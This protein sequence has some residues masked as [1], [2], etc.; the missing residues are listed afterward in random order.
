MKLVFF[1]TPRF[2]ATILNYLIAQQAEIIAVVSRPDK[3]Q[4]RS[5]KPLPTP[6]K[7]LAAHFNLPVYQPQ[8]VS[9]PVF[10]SFLRSLNAD[11]FIVAAFAEIFKENVLE[12]PKLG[13]INVHASI[14]PKYRGA[15]PIERAV[16]AGE[17]ESGV[18]IMRMAKDLDVGDILTIA[19]APIH[20]NMTAGE[21]S[22][23]LSQIGAQALWE[24]IQKLKMGTLQS[25]KQ[26]STLA[27]YAKKL[28]PEEGE[29]NWQRPFEEVH[30]H[31]RGVTPKPGA[32][33][34]VSIR[35]QK[36]RLLIKKALKEPNRSGQPGEILSQHPLEL[37]VACLT[38]ACRL[39]EV[40]LE[41]KKAMP[42]ET[43]LR[44]ISLTQIKF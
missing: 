31:I 32:W 16:M 19:K 25:F 7:E 10:A 5:A 14:L 37:V 1:G 26:D 12:I 15:A 2:A 23:V 6:V 17:E 42:I 28:K 43:F 44:G 3:P 9:D 38:G 24:V 8:K 22:D 4:K 27:T 13:C 35:D 33:C 40:Q 21:L 36:K 20:E 34:W 41:G 29:I 11:L 39:V 30:N 18:T